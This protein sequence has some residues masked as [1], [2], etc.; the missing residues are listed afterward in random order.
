[1][2][3]AAMVLRLE[4]DE[5]GEPLRMQ[6]SRCGGHTPFDESQPFIDQARTFNARHGDCLLIAMAELE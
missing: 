2:H 1:M 6:C 4:R 3:S 5:G